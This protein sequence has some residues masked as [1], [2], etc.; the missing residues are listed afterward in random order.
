MLPAD[1]K[2]KIALFCNVGEDAVISAKD[3]ITIYEVPLYLSQEGIDEIIMKLLDLPYRKR[4]L[5][6]WESLVEK[7]LNPRDE[8][9]I[10]MVGKYVA[11]EDSYKS[12]NEALA[13]GGVAN[14]LK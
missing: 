10:G 5:K 6:D 11:Y 1:L 2:R 3:V 9:T 4:N 7:I 13:H 12:L 8:V 14:H